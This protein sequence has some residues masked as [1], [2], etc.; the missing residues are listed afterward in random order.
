[1]V[2]IL[3][4]IFFGWPAVILSLA[5]SVTGILKKWPWMLVV[6]GV[7]SGPLAFYMSLLLSVQDLSLIR[8]IHYLYLSLPFF[9][10]GGAWA[11]HKNRKLWA[12]LL[13]IPLVITSAVLVFLVLTQKQFTPL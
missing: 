2:D 5:V 13:L 6:G 8:S 9:Q 1:M 12:W 11:V 3:V 7:L 10:F 4:K